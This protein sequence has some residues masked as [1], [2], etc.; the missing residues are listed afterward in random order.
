MGKYYVDWKEIEPEEAGVLIDA[1]ARYMNARPCP[2]T[3]D[4]A[5]ILC[6]KE[7]KEDAE[8]EE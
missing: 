1:V 5:A 2:Y 8:S 3:E 7:K 4:I 6:I